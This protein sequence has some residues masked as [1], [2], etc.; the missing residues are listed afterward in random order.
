MVA[1]RLSDFEKRLNKI[2]YKPSRY[3]AD[4]EIN[5]TKTDKFYLGVDYAIT[6]DPGYEFDEQM[7]EDRAFVL[8]DDNNEI[9]RAN[10]SN[11]FINPSEYDDCV[12]C[13]LIRTPVYRS[14]CTIVYFE[15]T[16]KHK[17][18]IP[19]A[20][21]GVQ[22]GFL[23]Y[24]T[25]YEYADNSY[26]NYSLIATLLND[27]PY[28]EDTLSDKWLITNDLR[29]LKYIKT[30]KKPARPKNEEDD[31]DDEEDEDDYNAGSVKIDDEYADIA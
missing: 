20:F 10:N 24:S 2:D 26:Y 18:K 25:F 17:F 9:I 22:R 21:L 6:L 7:R 4:D 30:I 16:A 28:D 19:D 1:F 23:E 8:V 3:I 5:I 12:I 15:F 13:Q 31:I 29:E 11:L 27:V 14:N